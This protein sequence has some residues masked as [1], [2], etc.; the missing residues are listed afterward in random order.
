[1]N[2]PHLLLAKEYWKE[3]LQPGDFA[4]DATCGNGHD[5]LY[6]SQLLPDGLVYGIDIQET[7]LEKTRLALGDAKNVRLFH[8]SHADPLPLPSRPRLIVYNLGYLPGGDKTLTTMT[9]STLESIKLSLEILATDGAI[10]ITC[11]PGHD[12]GMHEE[13]ELLSFVKD[14]KHAY[15]RWERERS[16]TL[17]WIK[18]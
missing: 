7:A 16:P 14:L 4:I 6:L 1:M 2:K 3:H 13:K 8:Q 12:E 15:H 18:N 17:L 10:S 9:S 5:T 11:Y